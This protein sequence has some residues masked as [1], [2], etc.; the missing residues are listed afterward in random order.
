MTLIL[1][2][3]IYL[4]GMV[5]L[6]AAI[7]LNLLASALKLATWYTFLNLVSQ[8]GLSPALHSLK[9]TDILFLFLIYPF[10]LGLSASVTLK[11]TAAFPL[12]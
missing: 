1:I 12:R 7:L 5:I 2:V 3:K 4:A 9:A 6:L 10:L 11:L 8:Q